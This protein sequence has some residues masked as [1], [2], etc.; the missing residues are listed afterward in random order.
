MDFLCLDFIAE[1]GDAACAL[2]GQIAQTAMA[3]LIVPK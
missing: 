1:F 2:K 3:S